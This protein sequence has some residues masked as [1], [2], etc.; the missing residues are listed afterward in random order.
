MSLGDRL[1]FA[2]ILFGSH[3]SHKER[4]GRRLRENSFAS[5][6]SSHF[7][8]SKKKTPKKPVASTMFSVVHLAEN[9]NLFDPEE[10]GGG[11]C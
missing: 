7:Q 1:S 2:T 10:G 3:G 5:A 6:C 8:S 11:E 4:F 9:T